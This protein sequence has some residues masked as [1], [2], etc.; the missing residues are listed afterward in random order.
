M[1]T[2]IGRVDSEQLER[3]VQKVIAA[4][5]AGT[6]TATQAI[7]SRLLEMGRLC[8]MKQTKGNLLRIDYIK[9]EVARLREVLEEDER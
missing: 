9:R 4:I 1:A 6:I 7:D 8:C 5:K 2:Q 3:N